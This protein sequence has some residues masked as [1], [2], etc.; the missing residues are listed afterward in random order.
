[1]AQLSF[2]PKEKIKGF[3]LLWPINRKP[4]KQNLP[5]PWWEGIQGRGNNK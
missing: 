2:V 4:T 5:L 1:M 3:P